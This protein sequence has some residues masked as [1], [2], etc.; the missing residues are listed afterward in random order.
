MHNI[1]ANIHSISTSKKTCV[2]SIKDNSDYVIE[3]VNIGLELNPDN[4]ANTVW[5]RN[6]IKYITSL[7]IKSKEDEK[8]PGTLKDT[9]TLKTEEPLF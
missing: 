8:N 7:Y 5:I 2:V 1:S 3:N 4:T 6:K 9:I